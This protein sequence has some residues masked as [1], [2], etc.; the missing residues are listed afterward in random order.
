MSLTST[1][2]ITVSIAP[3]EAEPLLSNEFYIESSNSEDGNLRIS[4]GISRSYVSGIFVPLISCKATGVGIASTFGSGSSSRLSSRIWI[5]SSLSVSRAYGICVLTYTKKLEAIITS[6]AYSYSHLSELWY[7]PEQITTSRATA[8]TALD[9]FL[10]FKGNA[11]CRS[12]V[13][14]VLFR[15]ALLP[16]VDAVG[17]SNILGSFLS[18]LK[19]AIF[20]VASS[21]A[22][23]S[24]SMRINPKKLFGL[25]TGR[26][27][28][29]VVELLIVTSLPISTLTSRASSPSVLARLL[30]LIATSNGMNS[31]TAIVTPRLVMFGHSTCTPTAIAVD[32]IRYRVIHASSLCIP[33]SFAD[34]NIIKKELSSVMVGRSFV[35]GIITKILSLS[36]SISSISSS[37]GIVNRTGVLRSTVSSIGLASL[38]TIKKISHIEADANSSS[39]SDASL[40][41]ESNLAALCS[42][43]SVAF[44]T[45]LS[46][47]TGLD[48]I[49]VSRSNSL[50]KK[51][52]LS[53]ILRGNSRSL[54]ISYLYVLTT[55]V[56]VFAN[57]AVAIS[58]S[59]NLGVLLY[60]KIK[61]KATSRAITYSK[62]KT[63]NDMWVHSVSEATCPSKLS[64]PKYPIYGTATAISDSTGFVR[65][66]DFLPKSRSVAEATS[67]SVLSNNWKPFRNTVIVGR[68]SSTS[69]ISQA[70]K[71]LG[72]SISRSLAYT[73]IARFSPFQGIVVG[74]SR[75]SAIL[76]Q[77][78][79]FEGIALERESTYGKLVYNGILRSKV[80]SKGLSYGFISGITGIYG[81][82]VSIS[83]VTGSKLRKTTVLESLVSELSASY[84]M[85]GSV[86]HFDKST[87][88]SRSSSSASRLEQVMSG[89]ATGSSLSK[90][91]LSLSS[92]GRIFHPSLD[93][94]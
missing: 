16:T 23:S 19:K 88:V 18:V 78:K 44:S 51:I 89:K 43:S 82:A 15:K 76:Y 5:P 28:A 83:N 24:G 7:I 34:A 32:I 3:A 68:T 47:M 69:I 38:S 53:G 63:I 92:F 73:T 30:D 61:G 6:R 14:A 79:S 54:S 27:T 62:A 17:R 90:A 50:A 9:V 87:T 84:S 86:I 20:G 42:S 40:G 2:L 60:S 26:A 57:T 46:R 56:R 55:R 70:K 35:S 25:V 64:L 93:L 29:N 81:E 75:S 1:K 4:G 67:P 94:F 65:P 74:L 33:V 31:A 72:S 59:E 49:V 48:S 21:V 85:L 41:H 80:I 77:T 58:F 10:S 13:S 71:I 36:S 45:E 22:V 37:S 52:G 12:T 66:T 8:P 11:L 91:T 39:V